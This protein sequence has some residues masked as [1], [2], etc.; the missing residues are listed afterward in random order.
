MK[1]IISGILRRLLYTWGH[2]SSPS[3]IR[4]LF[5][6]SID[7]S[8]SDISTSIKTFEWQM[9]YLEREGYKTISLSDYVNKI[10]HKDTLSER[11]VIITFDDGFKSVYLNAFPIL[12]GRGFIAT[13]FLTTDYINGSAG[14]ISRDLN[15]IGEKLLNSSIRSKKKLEKIKKTSSF[16]LLSWCEIREMSDYGIEIGSHTASH[17]WLER[18]D[19]E[20]AKEDIIRS[21]TVIEKRLNKSGNLFSYPYSN[22][23]QETKKI[24]RDLGFIAACGGD[25]RKDR[26]ADDLYGLKRTGPFPMESYFEFKFIFSPAYDWYISL[27]KNIKKGNLR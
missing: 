20:K 16:P 23:T 24:V 18:T 10:Y 13:I 15:L 12:K 14:W 21:K 3:K 4:I 17:L 5:Y 1:S 26:L 11:L 7:N 9:T 25:P 27:I 8:G 2:C 6:H 22:Y 19:P